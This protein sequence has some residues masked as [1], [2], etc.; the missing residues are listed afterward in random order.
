VATSTRQESAFGSA[1]GQTFGSEAAVSRT[2]TVFGAPSTASVAQRWLRTA[3]SPPFAQFVNPVV[4]PP[5]FIIPLVTNQVVI[6]KSR[7]MPVARA[8]PGTI[9]GDHTNAQLCFACRSRA[10]VS[11]FPLA[12]RLAE[13]MRAVQITR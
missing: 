8:R 1:F 11:S 13:R 6:S 4:I 10:K 12:D 7:R 3:G 9:C 5:A 2:A